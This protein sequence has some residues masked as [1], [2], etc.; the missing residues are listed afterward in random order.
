MIGNTQKSKV[1]FYLPFDDFKTKPVFSDVDEYLFYKKGVMH[2][3]ESRN[4]RIED[5]I[6]K[7]Y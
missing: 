6:S 1:K 7:I 3:I 4:K 5:Y 2:F